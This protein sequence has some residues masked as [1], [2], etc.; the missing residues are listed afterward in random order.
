MS[1]VN[2]LTYGSADHY[3]GDKGKEYFAWQSG[4]GDFFARILVHRFQEFIKSSD[5]VL[6]FGCGGGFVL[7]EIPC[8]RRIGI[9]INPVARQHA[10]GLGIECHASVADVADGIA[11][12][13]ISNHALEHVPY[14]I[15]VLKELR[16]KFKPGGLLALCVPI[17][18]FRLQRRYDSLDR[19]HHLHT[20]T[21]QLLGNTL[22][23]AGY[24]IIA[25]NYRVH[26]WP[27]KW[28]VA[29]YGR[30][31]WWMFNQVCYWYGI[32]TGKGRELLAVARP[33][34]NAGSA[35]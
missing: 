15:G 26:C 16:P 9:E 19:N 8:A 4:G 27:G 7:K 25:I 1:G 17:D 11:D 32:L 23:E 30:L 12:V 21:A 10:L 33:L 24:E 34:S 22:V 2:N 5:T 14:P 31:P 6:D 28:T 29:A 35:A 18:N 20:W 13:V 3:L